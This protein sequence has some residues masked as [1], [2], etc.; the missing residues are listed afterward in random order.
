G[1]GARPAAPPAAA[2]S[3]TVASTVAPNPA[4]AVEL[5]LQIERTVNGRFESAELG[6]LRQ[7]DRVRFRVRPPEDGNLT[8]AAGGRTTT[9]T[10]RRGQTYYLPN[11]EGL[12]PGDGPLEVAIALQP[13]ATVETA[14]LFRSRQQASNAPAGSS[15]G[16]MRDSAKEQDATAV[17]KAVAAPRTLR[18]R[19]EFRPR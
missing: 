7:G 9:A 2:P 17:Q 18:L 6:A 8:F 14:N 13:A 1:G 3:P 19:L 5:D 15:V 12:P 16:A 10:A 11:A 4:T